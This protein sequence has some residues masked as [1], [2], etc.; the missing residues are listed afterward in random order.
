MLL[1]QQPAAMQAVF[2]NN[3]WCIFFFFFEE[4]VKRRL[5]KFQIPKVGKCWTKF[6]VKAS[7]LL[8]WLQGALTAAAFW[9]G[10]GGPA[11]TLG[12][13]KAAQSVLVLVLIRQAEG[14]ITS[15]V[16]T[17]TGSSCVLTSSHLAIT[18]LA[19]V[20]QFLISPCSLLSLPSHFWCHP[21]LFSAQ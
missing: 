2:I 3:P 19:A 10:A 8:L 17:V 1:P 6:S 21:A 7:C 20:L 16:V 18:P 5:F 9:A 4:K 13:N 14:V 12:F 15:I 11:Q